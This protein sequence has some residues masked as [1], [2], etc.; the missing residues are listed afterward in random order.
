MDFEGIRLNEISQTEKRQTL[1][2][3]LICGSLTTTTTNQT[4]RKKD[5]ICSYQRQGVGEG[6][7]EEGGQKVQTS[8]YKIKKY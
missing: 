4:H 1:F 5:Q 3:S 6:K 8:N 7:L 2:I